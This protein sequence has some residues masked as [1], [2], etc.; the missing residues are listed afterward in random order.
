MIILF[1]VSGTFATYF[2]ES[3][4]RSLLVMSLSPLK[5]CD[6]SSMKTFVYFKRFYISFYLWPAR[7][8]SLNLAG[9]KSV[10]DRTKKPLIS[11][12]NNLEGRKI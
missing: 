7:L 1:F 4:S 10:R 8:L 2:L 3:L 5:P 6:Q 11:F 12:N 9:V